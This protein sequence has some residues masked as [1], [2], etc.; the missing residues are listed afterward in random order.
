MGKRK[1]STKV[2]AQT[3]V[4]EQSQEANVIASALESIDTESESKEVVEQAVNELE[5][6]E[7][8]TEAYAE[9]TPD[10]SDETAPAT[11]E[12]EASEKAK[13]P[14]K[15]RVMMKC[16]DR[17]IEVI[18]GRSNMS[19]ALILEVGDTSLSAKKLEQ[20]QDEF[21]AKCD[22]DLAKKVGEKAV[23]LF[24]Y[25]TKGGEMN[26]VMKRAFTV[27]V[28]KGE[29][30]SGDKGNLQANLIEK[31]SLGTTRSQSNQMFML[32][33]ALK[34]TIR[35]KGRMVPNPDSVILARVQKDLGLKA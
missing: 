3:A 12:A 10:S 25:L 5:Q 22:N 19:D 1:S 17:I 30:T 32:F 31:Y 2:N 7:A 20:A 35:E 13:E 33:P 4:D 18:G 21:L 9:Q 11:S 29:L 27:L 24:K 6:G 26:E 28:D 8:V 14:K 34:I 15:P 16:S 23:L